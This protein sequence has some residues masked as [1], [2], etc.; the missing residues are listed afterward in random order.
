RRV[1]A[2]RGPKALLVADTHHLRSPILGM[3]RY[4]AEERYDRHVLLY[5]RHHAA[6]IASAGIGALFWQPGLTFPHDDAVVRAARQARRATRLAFVGQAGRFHP[7]R[8]RLLEALEARGVPV[9][10]RAVGQREGL[11]FYGA[12]LLGF[13]ASLNGD[14]NLRALEILAGG[15]ALVTD[16]LAPEAGLDL[17]GTD[18]RG[19]I[20]Y[21]DAAELAERAA[22]AL[23][24]PAGTAAIGAAGAAWFDEHWSAARRRGRFEAMLRDGRAEPAFALP[25]PGTTVFFPG[26]TDRLLG[27]AM[28]YEGLQELHRTQETVRVALGAGVPEDFAALCRTLPRVAVAPA[29]A[30]AAP[31]LLAFSRA[32]ADVA[33]TTSADRLWCCDALPG[34]FPILA[35][36]LAPAGYRL[37][38]EAVAVLCREAAPAAPPAAASGPRVL[39]F[40]DDP[41]SGGVAQ[42]NHSLL[43]GLAADGLEVACAQTRAENPLVAAQRAAGVAHHWIP[44][45]T[46]GGFARTLTDRETAERIFAAARPDLVV[47]SDCCPVSNLAARQVALE[48]GLPYVVVV[49]FVGAYLADRFRAVLPA[50]AA[51]YAAARAVVA[52]SAENLALL[53]ARFGLGAGAGEVVHYGRPERFFAPCDVAA[54]ERLRAGLGLPADAVVAFTAARLSP[55]KGY[56]YQLEA[57]RRLAAEPAAAR[58]HFVWAGEGEQRGELEAAIAAAGLGGRV[59]LLGHRWD[60]EAWY[61]A[62]DLFVLPSDLEGMPLAIMEAMAK[63]LPVAATAVS[64]IPEELGPTGRL[65]PPAAAGRDALVRALAAVLLEWTRDPAARAAAGEAGRVRARELFREER[66]V[67]RTV[68]LVRSHA[69]APAAPLRATA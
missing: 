23:A 64:G 32:A 15:A 31:D 55:V 17:L 42:Y 8:L 59:H 47:F 14:L 62:A 29:D 51:Q 60:V 61:D 3:L 24:D 69:A 19:L 18:G 49:G 65:L 52:V 39:L 63:G 16:R 22:R 5:D 67:A 66:M 46:R 6:L 13:N 50:L 48:R 36:A 4:M 35:E 44:Y 57:A 27:A 68:A 2:F 1:D 10:S 45:D 9:E 43:L 26:D 7:R 25:A 37:V 56:A 41:D 21:G 30:V 40:T 34:D 11:A 38:S 20:A 53:R 58:L 12:S 54:R 28:V 33:T